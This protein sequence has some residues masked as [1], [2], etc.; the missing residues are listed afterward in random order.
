MISDTSLV[1]LAM[2]ATVNVVGS[3]E[4]ALAAHRPALLGTLFVAAMFATIGV[5]TANSPMS[6]RSRPVRQS[7]PLRRTG[8]PRERRR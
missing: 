4:V 3:A 1:L 8:G 2:H 7:Q 6:R 5:L